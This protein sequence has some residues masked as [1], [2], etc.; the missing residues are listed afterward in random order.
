MLLRNEECRLFLATAW[1]LSYFKGEQS[2]LLWAGKS[3]PQ[4]ILA[5]QKNFSSCLSL[6]NKNLQILQAS[7][8]LNVCQ[9]QLICIQEA[10]THTDVTNSLDILKR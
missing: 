1:I 2:P 6:N 8:I 4:Q 3:L 9:K 10:S 7:A 5:A